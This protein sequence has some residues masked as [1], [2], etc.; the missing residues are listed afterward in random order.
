MPE[1]RGDVLNNAINEGLQM[2]LKM[3]PR[4]KGQESYLMQHFDQRKIQ[5]SVLRA[6]EAIRKQE[7]NGKELSDERKKE[8]VYGSI[9]NDVSS[10]RLFDDSGKEVILRKGLEERVGQGFRR[11]DAREI[12][13][14]ENYLD[15]ALVA[16]R[17]IYAMMK[18]GDYAQHMPE[19]AESVS[20]IYN[21]GFLD[22]AV[23]LLKYHGLVDNNKY[24]MLKR[25][26]RR[27]AEEGVTGAEQ[28]INKYSSLKK[29]TAVL[30]VISGAS[31]FVSSL[32]ITGNVIGESVN[33]AFPIIG[34]VSIFTGIILWI[35]GR[36][37]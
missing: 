15:K 2:L 11:K 28:A 24:K 22:S 32:K 37:I 16:F 33:S 34:I 13:R 14:G 6:N 1:E 10:G 31:F 4:L 17:D 20:T 18:T 23:D 27:K 21:M 25:N 35:S 29:T 5:E 19:F 36:R 12:S 9:I 3:H 26:V 7:I 8:L 30:L